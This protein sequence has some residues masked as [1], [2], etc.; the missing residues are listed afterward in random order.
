MSWIR[1]NKTPVIKALDLIYINNGAMLTC[2]FR[3]LRNDS[4]EH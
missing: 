1:S 3:L 2:T 4:A